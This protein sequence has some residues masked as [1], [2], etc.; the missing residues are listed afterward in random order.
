MVVMRN[1]CNG[2]Q[3]FISKVSMAHIRIFGNIWR[4][5][6]ETKEWPIRVISI[7]QAELSALQPAAAAALHS[8]NAKEF[9]ASSFDWGPSPPL[10]GAP[11]SVA[12]LTSFYPKGL[13]LLLPHYDQLVPFNNLWWRE[14][15]WDLAKANKMPVTVSMN[16][17]LFGKVL[18]SVK[19]K[20][21]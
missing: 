12:L 13:Q 19:K 16:V 8:F 9:V 10:S 7:W 5:N 15:P 11:I 21:F 18:I 1:V 17:G 14:A 20:V 3:D 2:Q 6:V 4:L